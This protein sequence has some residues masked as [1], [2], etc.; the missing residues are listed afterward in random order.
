MGPEQSVH[1]VHPALTRLFAALDTAG[2][3]WCLLRGEADIADP[4]GT[5]DLLVAASDLARLDTVLLGE[6]FL[7]VP[8]WGAHRCYVGYDAA[9]GPGPRRS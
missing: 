6:G 8:A 7:R 9:T 1:A 3:A 4:T 2:I 5:V